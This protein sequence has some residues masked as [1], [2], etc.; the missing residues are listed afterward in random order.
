M[1]TAVGWNVRSPKEG[2]YLWLNNRHSVK[3]P[4]HDFVLSIFVD[5]SVLVESGCYIGGVENHRRA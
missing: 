2:E 4:S 1:L 3:L 5:E